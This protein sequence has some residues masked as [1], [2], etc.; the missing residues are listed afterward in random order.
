MEGLCT[1]TRKPVLQ[2]E[3]VQREVPSPSPVPAGPRSKSKPTRPKNE[4]VPGYGDI[5]EI[6]DQGE[7]FAKHR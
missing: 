1:T 2:P 5:D 6:I 7:G 4:P 3:Y